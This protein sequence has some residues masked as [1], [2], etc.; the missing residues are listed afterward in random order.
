M[1]RL[2]KLW[3]R[4]SGCEP[5]EEQVAV[6]DPIY[7]DAFSDLEFYESLW[8]EKG[9]RSVE[10][11]SVCVRH[12]Q[13]CHGIQSFYRLT[14]ADGTKVIRPGPE[15]FSSRGFYAH[16][17][18][19]RDTWIHMVTDEFIKGLR[20]RQGDI[21]N[22]I[23]F[24]T[25]R[26]EVHCGGWG[27]ISVNMI[28]DSPSSMRIV[29]F[30]GTTCGVC[31]RIGFHAKHFV[32]KKLGTYIF[33]RELVKQ[34]RATVKSTLTDKSSSSISTSALVENAS[35]DIVVKELIHLDEGLFREI[36]TFLI[37]SMAS[38]SEKGAGNRTCSELGRDT[39][40]NEITSTVFSR[41][42]ACGY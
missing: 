26:R 25:N 24:V 16:T 11:S 19:S 15:N 38:L 18:R 40:Q 23:T 27:G 20:I 2:G 37:P 42:V 10:I 17:A 33:V 7:D 22:N 12:N 9:C 34:G 13:Y 8:E 28:P 32:W 29:A 41:G 31:K 21:V 1:E 39:V 35:T 30:S 3:Y 36:I 5:N 4:F 14:F 6:M